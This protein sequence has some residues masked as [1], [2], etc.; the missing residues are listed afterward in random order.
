MI[1][2]QKTNEKTITKPNFQQSINKQ[3]GLQK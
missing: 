3:K 2:Q 1:T